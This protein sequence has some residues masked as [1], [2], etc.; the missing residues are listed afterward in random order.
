MVEPSTPFAPP[1]ALFPFPGLAAAAARAPLG[2]PRESLLA[3]LMVVRLAQGMRLPHPLT[4][5]AR[6]ARAEQAKAWLTAITLP[7]KTRTS[8]QRGL[9]ASAQGDRTVMAEALHAVTDVT[10]AHLD[11]VARSEMQL[12]ADALRRD[13]V[14]LAAPGD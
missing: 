4:V 7:P 12:L 5:D 11:R 8:I 3:A 14:A 2:G 1:R 10:A 9:Q 6:R 13:A